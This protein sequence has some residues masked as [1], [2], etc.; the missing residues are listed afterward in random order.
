MAAT[1]HTWKVV[2]LT[3]AA[4]L[5]ERKFYSQRATYLAVNNERQKILEG[6]S[7]VKRAVA[8]QWDKAAGRWM[9]FERL[10]LKAEADSLAAKIRASVEEAKNGETK[11]LGDFTVHILVDEG[12]QILD[13]VK[14][15][16]L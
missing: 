10:D 5:P 2:F 8:Y 11:D 13:V 16:E 12:K 6:V 3:D 4:P 7:R 14:K 1:K 9:T 15:G